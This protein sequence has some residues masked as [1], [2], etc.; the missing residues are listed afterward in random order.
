LGCRPNGHRGSRVHVVDLAAVRDVWVL[1]ADTASGRLSRLG[2][3]RR[4]WVAHASAP[5]HSTSS[6]GSS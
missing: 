4:R 1:D 3:K 2:R 6:W 5:N